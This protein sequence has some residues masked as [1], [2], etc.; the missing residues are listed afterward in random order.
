[1]PECSSIDSLVTPYVDGE[2][3]DGDRQTVDAHLRVCRPCRARIAAEQT[4]RELMQAHKAA[5]ESGRAPEALHARCAAKAETPGG[6]PH[7]ALS[8]P[9]LAP[10]TPHLAPSTPHLAPSTA[11]STPHSA[12]F[13]ERVWPH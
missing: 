13:S 9:H 5:L 11:L 12:P 7:L 2:L 3:P 6:I 8:T 10:S 4:T 1:M